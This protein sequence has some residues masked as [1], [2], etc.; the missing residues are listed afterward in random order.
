MDTATAREP[1]AAPDTADSAGR[2]RA[3]RAELARRGLAGFV[4][5]RADE[6]Q[7]EYVPPR[8]ERLAWLTGFIG[9]A[10][11]AVVLAET[12]AIFVDGRY[13]LQ[14]GDQV[15]TGLFTPLHSGREPATDWIAGNLPAGG[16]LGFDPWLHTSDGAAR[17]ARACA[18]AG[19][20][21][22]PCRSNPL[23]AV[24][25]DQPEPP[26]APV[27]PHGIE[28]AGRESSDKR[29]DM[30][31]KLKDQGASAAVL[32]LPDSIAWLLN[33]RGGDVSRSP[34]PL[35][36]AI[37]QDDGSVRLF[38]DK[39]KVTAELRRHL[40]R[41]V[42]L[43]SPSKLGP[44]LDELGAGDGA[45]LADPTS[46]AEWVFQRLKAA[47]ATVVR[48]A[49][50]CLLAKAR[51]NP[52]EIEGAR[53]AHRRDGAALTR[54]LAWLAREAPGGR[55]DEIA[56]A[57]RL[58]AYRRENPEFRD[59]SFDTISGAGANGAIV[60]YRVSEASNRRLEP[61]MLYLV[62]SGAQYPDGTTDVTRT[63]AIGPPPAEARDRFTRVLQGHIALASARF[64]ADT[65]GTQLDVLARLP[66][67]RAGL[68]YDHGTGHGVGSYLGV[69]E[70]P[71]RISKLPSKVALLPG[72]IVSNEPGY[73]KTGEYGIR[74][75]NLVT[76]VELER[77]AGAEQDMLGFETLTLAPIDQALVDIS[78][79]SEAEIAWLDDYHARVREILTPL[80]DAETADWLAQ[81]TAPLAR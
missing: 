77:E 25:P 55:V 40:D 17:L 61:G 78:I 72:M 70:G 12:A 57:E 11:L 56:A 1:G 36:F 3:L 65:S 80:V 45:V 7:G 59:L 66:L 52:V 69:H 22:E 34:L 6:H 14:V 26:L 31:E 15:D 76:V 67:W 74:I 79:M 8:A 75:E 21:L 44:A 58:E 13:T 35:G 63:V 28:Y 39:R 5:P 2:L 19:G 53:A 68:D 4:V 37:L 47:R 33:I 50:P 48:G 51:K 20:T 23:D 46:A 32:T 24:W 10:G 18:K 81:A 64:P 62:D 73:Y 9:S 29:R 60:H 54:F 43:L 27:A 41:D 42:E 30:A 16:R 49:D 38:M 71:Q